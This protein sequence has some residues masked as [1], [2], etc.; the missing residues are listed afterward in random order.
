MFTA[1]NFSSTEK[2]HFVYYLYSSVN[3]LCLF[4][5]ILILTFSM[6]VIDGVAW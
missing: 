4:I 1:L 6:S 5:C 3:V 2:V